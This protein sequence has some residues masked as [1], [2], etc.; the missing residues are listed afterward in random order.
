VPVP[1]INVKIMAFVYQMH[2]IKITLVNVSLDFWVSFVKKKNMSVLPTH[3]N[4]TQLV[5]ILLTD[6]FVNVDQILPVPIVPHI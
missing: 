5:T 1:E 4:L 3:A 6:T 2:K